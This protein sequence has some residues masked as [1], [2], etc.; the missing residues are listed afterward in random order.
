[1]RKR[2]IEAVIRASSGLAKVTDPGDTDYNHGDLAP[3]V[4]L[5]EINRNLGP[6][7]KPLKF[8]AELRFGTRV[9]LDMQEDWIARL[10]YK[11]IKETMLEAASKGWQA[12]TLEHPVTAFVTGAAATRKVQPVLGAKLN[13]ESSATRRR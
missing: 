9:P 13:N 2:N 5:E 8:Q 12:N 1:M 7:K 3:R 10:N 4:H 6:N 11:N